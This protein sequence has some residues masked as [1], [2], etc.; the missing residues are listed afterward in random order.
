MVS[1]GI[2]LF[3]DG[4][5]FYESVKET[6]IGESI[7][8][9]EI[10]ALVGEEYGFLEDWKKPVVIHHEH[11]GFGINHANPDK[12]KQNKRS[13]QWAV[14]LA[15]KFRAEKI[16][17]HPG[18][19]DHKNCSIQ[20]MVRQ[21]TALWDKRMI[22]ENLIYISDNFYMFCCEKQ[23]LEYLVKKFKTGICLDLAHAMLTACQLRK[24]PEAVL[25]TLRTLPIRH[26]HVSDSFL[27]RPIDMHLHI[28]SGNLPL[29]KCL[30][31]IPYSVDITLETGK[32]IDGYK[33]DKVFLRRCLE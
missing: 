4:K 9:I 1:I 14:H 30:K 6:E 23:E 13:T 27:K 24:K 29:K 15:D 31:Y 10:M 3:P 12:W 17:V 19:W 21:L 26:V 28:G 16:I 33:K 25:E 8:F 22:F 32:D 11:S 2:K 20:E 5:K 7:D 18:H